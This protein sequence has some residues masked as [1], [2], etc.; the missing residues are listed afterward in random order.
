M[1]LPLYP[2]SNININNTITN[3]N[4]QSSQPQPPMQTQTLVPTLGTKL[5]S[6][7]NARSGSSN[8]T[9]MAPP[10]KLNPWKVPISP[11]TSSSSSC[12]SSDLSPKTKSLRVI[13]SEEEEQHVKKHQPRRDQ[14]SSN[15]SN[16]RSSSSSIANNCHKNESNTKKTHL[17]R[18]K[19]K[20]MSSSYQSR[21][22][23]N[24]T[25]HNRPKK[26]QNRDNSSDGNGSNGNNGQYPRP[27]AINSYDRTTQNNEYS[28]NHGNHG[29][30]RQS[31]KNGIKKNKNKGYKGHYKSTTFRRNQNNYCNNYYTN[32]SMRNSNKIS[33]NP[34]FLL[35]S[36]TEMSLSQQN[37]NKN[38]SEIRYTMMMSCQEYYDE[39]SRG[40]NMK[41]QQMTKEERNSIVAL[42]CEMVGVGEHGE[43]SALA[44][45][46]IVN[47]DYD[48]LLDTYVKVDEPVTDYRTFVSGVRDKDIQSDKAMDL[49]VCRN[50]VL[51]I[52]KGR[53]LV[54]HGLENDLGA[55]NITHPKCD[56]R[57]TAY[58]PLYMTATLVSPMGRAS[59]PESRKSSFSSYTLTPSVMESDCSSTGSNS[60][61]LSTSSESQS[62]SLSEI[63]Y[64]GPMMQLKPR[65]LKE[66][67]REWLEI[68]IQ[69]NGEEHSRLEGDLAALASYKLSRVQCEDRYLAVS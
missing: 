6:P 10:T 47:W 58:Y 41:T 5:I 32:H 56:T 27:T 7:F 54:G 65:K 48:V 59:R 30:G 39:I 63:T 35:P 9:V 21:K 50:M 51:K 40:E 45:V 52:L 62:P 28:N 2:F 26:K 17:S 38:I 46:S 11:S 14:S 22:I 55:L 16:S 1:N 20:Q 44:R 57:D 3:A 13:M 37:Y 42:D 12:T 67:A 8:S 33:T 31:N 4:H 34:E 53:I 24:K 64:Q 43:R 19:Q 18:H 66:I 69:R 36:L 25:H 23:N 49:H 68:M 29:H 61:F 60:S 15:N